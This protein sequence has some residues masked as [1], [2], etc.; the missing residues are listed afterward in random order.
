MLRK[1]CV[2]AILQKLSTIFRIV[3]LQSTYCRPTEGD[4]CPPK[5]C[6]IDTLAINSSRLRTSKKR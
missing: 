2:G 5:A 6:N 4:G 1:H 3:S